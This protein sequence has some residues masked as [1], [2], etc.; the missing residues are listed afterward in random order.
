MDQAEFL[1]YTIL[2]L[3][4]VGIPYAIVGSFAS[5]IWG[6]PRF[7]QHIDILIHLSAEQVIT[8]CNEFPASDFYVSESAAQDA[9]T[10][11]GQLNVIHPA[12]GNKIDFMI[13]GD[14]DWPTQ[15]LARRKQLQVFSDL[16]ASVAAPEDVILGKLIY[17]Q[18]G[19]SDK[20][21]RDIA[22]ILQL[23]SN[24]VDRDY[25]AKFAAEFGVVEIWQAVLSR[26]D[27]V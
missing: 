8:L 12:S 26:V 14:G 24:L 4:R 7:T 2:V 6:E 10:Q 19:G 25:V 15:Q 27:S 18:E 22:G 13:V 3:D 9:V 16:A 1:R 11:Y 23:S 5:G 17:Y 21:L 20:H